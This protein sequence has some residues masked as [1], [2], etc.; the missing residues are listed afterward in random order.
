VRGHTPPATDEI[1]MCRKTS[2]YF[3]RRSLVVSKPC[4]PERSRGTLRFRPMKPEA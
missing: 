4:H 3:S 2:F 1:S